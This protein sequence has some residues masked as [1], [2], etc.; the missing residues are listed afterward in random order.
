MGYDTIIVQRRD[1][2]AIII[3]NRPEK[4][5]ALSTL[6]RREMDQA[7][8]EAEADDSIA[9]IVITG[10]GNKAFSAGADIHE[11]TGSSPEEVSQRQA[12]GYQY[13]WHTATCSKPTIG[14]INGLA[15]GGGA[16]LATTVDMRVGCEHSRFRFL[17]AQ[18]GRVNSTW[19]LP[20][21]V[22]MPMAMELLT[23]ARVVE[24][25]EAY[26][27]GLLN[28]LV[29]AGRV[30]EEAVEMGRLIGQN[31]QR[32]LR[33][34]KRLVQ[35]N[36][37][38]TWEQMFLQEKEAVQSDLQPTA[39]AAESFKDFLGRRGGSKPPPSGGRPGGAS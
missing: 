5:N 25:E 35:Q 16:L 37:G 26:R 15:Y 17:A 10:A 2:T 1:T 12:A 32:M 22:G 3:M 31:D 20:F 36:V 27:M 6:L 30:L 9:A 18:Y 39:T 21:I 8:S 34:I 38:L 28:R 13:S 11:M 33:G 23:T 29:P 7:I 4:L 19:T 24:P 14:A